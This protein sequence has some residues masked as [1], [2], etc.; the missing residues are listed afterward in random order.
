MFQGEQSEQY[1]RLS[2]T[3]NELS[4]IVDKI[5]QETIDEMDSYDEQ[6]LRSVVV[7]AQSSMQDAKE[8]LEANR[9]YQRAKLAIKDL[10][11]GK[12]EVDSRQKAKTTYA[13]YRLKEMGKE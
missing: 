4:K 6:Q 5:G 13:L 2:A 11:A 7:N 3:N 10:S 1:A 12:R 8:E 9:E